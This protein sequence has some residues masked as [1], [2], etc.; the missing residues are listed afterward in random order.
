M[1]ISKTMSVCSALKNG[2][3]IKC[4][5]KSYIMFENDYD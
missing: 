4:L 1:I 2:I 5:K 3:C